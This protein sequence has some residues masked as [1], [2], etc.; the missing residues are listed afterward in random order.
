MEVEGS[1]ASKKGE[2]GGKAS[3]MVASGDSEEGRPSK[4]AARAVISSVVS[5]GGT[6]GTRA[7]EG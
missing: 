6:K 7:R 1:E 4:G 2:V 3:G 5:G